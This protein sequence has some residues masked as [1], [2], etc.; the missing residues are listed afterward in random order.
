LA[1]LHIA[2]MAQSA[3]D[4]QKDGRRSNWEFRFNQVLAFNELP[5]YAH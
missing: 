5:A 4:S 3:D 2:A 1:L